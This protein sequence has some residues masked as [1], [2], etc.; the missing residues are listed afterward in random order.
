MNLLTQLS[1][2][3]EQHGDIPWHDKVFQS[4][5]YEDLWPMVKLFGGDI[6][7]LYKA[8]DNKI[9]RAHV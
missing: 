7:E 5:N 4:E 1:L 6:H 8:L 3:I 2:L 9:G